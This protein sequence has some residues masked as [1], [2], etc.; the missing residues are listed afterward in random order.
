MK[1]WLMKSEPSSYSIDDLV[2]DGETM[3]DGVRNYQA[4]NNLREM[5]EG[6]LAFFYRSVKKPA[7]VGIMRIES[8]AEV[9]KT[10]D[11]DIWSAVK[12][13]VVEKLDQ[14]IPLSVIKEHQDLQEMR[15]VKQSRLS[16]SEVTK[17]EWDIICNL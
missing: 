12:V 5:Q 8:G 10:A 7:I 14:E 6:D 11:S 17:K 15:L 1:Y 9:D 4:R 16:V 3:W 2:S 13:S